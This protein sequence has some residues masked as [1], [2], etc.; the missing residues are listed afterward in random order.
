MLQVGGL[1]KEWSE[2]KARVACGSATARS[3]SSKDKE[4]ELA[5]G[6]EG[7]VL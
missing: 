7:A 5:A 1:Q 3:T 6:A 2:G 4:R